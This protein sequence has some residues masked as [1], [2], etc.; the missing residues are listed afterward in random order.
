VI[1]WQRYV[2]ESMKAWPAF[3]GFAVAGC[4]LSWLA[5]AT[6]LPLARA[7]GAGAPLIT[8]APRDA[9]G[10]PI[11]ISLFALARMTLYPMPETG[12]GRKRRAKRKDDRKRIDGPAICL[13]LAAV[14][15]A[16]ALVAAPITELIVGTVVTERGYVA[17][18]P[19]PLERPARMRWIRTE[20]GSPQA[21][22]PQSVSL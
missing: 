10:L 5:L 1:E 17:C 11:S 4:A 3:L 15:I 9:I 7:I 19:L 14:G 20:A 13:A 16:L 6:L 22:C 2:S 21:Q 18:P 12:P 8:L